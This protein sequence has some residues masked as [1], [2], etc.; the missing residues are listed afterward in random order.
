MRFCPYPFT[1]RQKVSLCFQRE[2]FFQSEFNKVLFF[3]VIHSTTEHFETSGVWHVFV[4]RCDDREALQ[5]HLEANDIQTNIHYPTAP[6]KQECYSEYA[7]LSLPVTEK[8]HKEVMSLPISP[9][10]T[11]EE[12][13]KVVE[14]VNEF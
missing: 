8:I 6:H 3:E 5:K 12:V 10:M 13:K 7:S 11:D 1:H 4:V 14:V 9:V 2:T